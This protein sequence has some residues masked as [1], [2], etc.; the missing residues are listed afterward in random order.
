MALRPP[1][2]LVCHRRRPCASMWRTRVTS[3]ASRHEYSDR[4]ASHQP[5]ND[6]N[7][8]KKK[9]HGV[10]VIGRAGG[11]QGRRTRQ[12]RDARQDPAPHSGAL[13]GLLVV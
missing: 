8:K 7:K 1:Q 5:R 3:F 10:I 6:Y 13:A 11:G 4:A 2:R 12:D 9:N